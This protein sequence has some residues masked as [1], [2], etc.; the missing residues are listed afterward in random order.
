MI[1]IWFIVSILYTSH[2]PLIPHIVPLHTHALFI[3]IYAPLKNQFQ[4]F[5]PLQ[6]VWLSHCASIVIRHR[7]LL[8]ELDH[9]VHLLAAHCDYCTDPCGFRQWLWC[10]TTAR[11]FAS[12]REHVDGH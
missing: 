3:R 9:D 5:R 8:V 1:Q 2:P 12:S 4:S 6:T 7:H 10:T 11:Q